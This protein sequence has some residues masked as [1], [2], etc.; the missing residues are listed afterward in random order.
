MTQLDRQS[1]QHDNLAELFRRDA[2]ELSR[3]LHDALTLADL[4]AIAK[5][6]YLKR[7]RRNPGSR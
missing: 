3:Q 5:V 6:A 4:E 2:A 7:Q 1:A